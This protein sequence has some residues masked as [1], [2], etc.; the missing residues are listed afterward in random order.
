METFYLGFSLKLLSI[1]FTQIEK[2]VQ[3]FIKWYQLYETNIVR[4]QLI[5]DQQLVT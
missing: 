5:P 2:D 1:V 3:L 4:F